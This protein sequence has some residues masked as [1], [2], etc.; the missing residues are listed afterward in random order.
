[1]AS[2]IILH[3]FDAEYITACFILNKLGDILVISKDFTIRYNAAGAGDSVDTLC[4]RHGEIGN[5]N[6]AIQRYLCRISP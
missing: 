2:R 5:Q 4:F 6:I 3:G 1:M